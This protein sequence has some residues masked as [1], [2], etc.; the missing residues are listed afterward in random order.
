MIQHDNIATAFASFDRTHQ[1]RCTGTD[2]EDVCVD[3]FVWH[4]FKKTERIDESMSKETGD[5]EN[6]KNVLLSKYAW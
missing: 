2:D 6:E 4:D 5:N 3:D 1:A